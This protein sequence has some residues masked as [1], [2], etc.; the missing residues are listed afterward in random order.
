MLDVMKT[1]LIL[2]DS[3]VREVLLRHAI[4]QLGDSFEVKVWRDAHS[5]ITECEALF[6]SAALM[7]AHHLNGFV[8]VLGQTLSVGGDCDT[9]AAIVGGIVVLSAGR[10]SI[11]AEWLKAREVIQI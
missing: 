3:P 7:A 4:A 9:N 11:P 8:D 1:I 10:G 2:E 5:M 6:S